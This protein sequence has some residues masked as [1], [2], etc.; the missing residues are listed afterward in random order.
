[1]NKSLCNHVQELKSALLNMKSTGET[2]FEGLISVTLREISG[3]PFRLARSG[4]QYGVDGKPAYPGDA[5]CFECKRYRKGIRRNEVISKIGELLISDAEV[6]IWVL[7]A[8][9]QIGTT[10]A[11]DIRDL[12]NKIGIFIL[13][14]DWSEIDLP[15]FAVALAMGKTRVRKFLKDNIGDVKTLRKAFA[16]LKAI[17]NSHDFTTHAD[18]IQKQCNDPAL[19]ITLAQRANSELLSEIFTSR[20]LAKTKFGQ[21]LSP[22]DT[23]LPNVRERKVL[24]D[25][26]QPYFSSPPDNTVNFVVGGEGYGK[27]WIVAQTWMA[28]ENKPLMVLMTP[29]DFTKP[30]GQLNVEDLI[31]TKISDQTEKETTVVTKKQ[32]YR[33]FEKWRN[34]PLVDI[35]RVIVVIDGINQRPTY[36]WARYIDS[37]SSELFKLGGRLIVTSRTSYFAN[38]VK[39]RLDVGFTETTVPEWTI[40]EL[41]EILFEHNIKASDLQPDVTRSLRNPRL[42]GIALEILNRDDITNFKELS[43]SRLLFE[44][45]RMSEKDALV[46]QSAR[47]FA[48]RLQTHAKKILRR[49]HSKQ[50]DDLNIFDDQMRF[51]ADGRFFNAV[52]DDPT[53][54]FINDDGL[55]LALGFAVINLLRTAQRNNRNLDAELDMILDPISALDDTSNAIL[56]ALT[57]TTI[58]KS[59]SRDITVS[60]IQGFA[61]LQN[62]DQTKFFAFASLARS[63]PQDFMDAAR[64]LCL[65]AEYQPNFDWIQTALINAGQNSH[66]WHV[67]ASNIHSWLAVYSLSPKR[68][69]FLVS[70]RSSQE[71]IKEEYEKNRNKIEAKINLFSKNERSILRNLNKENGDLSSLSRLAFILLAGKPLALFSLSFLNWSFSKALNPDH[72]EP[73]KEFIDLVTLNKVDWLDTR[74]ALLEVSEKLGDIDVSETGKWAL[75]TILRATGHSD[76]GKE[77]KSILKDLTKDWPHRESWSLI[78]DYCSTDPCNPAST[79]PKNITKTAEKYAALD[80][81]KLRNYS[82]QTSEDLF[83]SMA[84]PGIA[85]FKPKIAIAKHLEFAADVLNR[86]GSPLRQG[87]FELCLNN[88]LLT[89]NIAREFIKK[90]DV[91]KTTDNTDDLLEQDVSQYIL[92]LA[93]PFLTAREQVDI[94]LSN[95]ADDYIPINLKELAKPLGEAEFEKLLETVCVGHNE[96]N[97]YLLLDLATSTSIRLSTNARAHIT[98][99][100]QS[101]SE[102]VRVQALVIIAQSGDNEMLTQVVKSKW[103][104]AAIKKENDTEIRY[105]S[106]ALLKAAERGLL[107]HNEALDRIS[108]RLYGR[109]AT[110]LG[111]DAIK[112]VVHR[113]DTLIKNVASLDC[114]LSAPKIEIQESGMILVDELSSEDKNYN[115]FHEFMANLT[116]SN[117]RIL[118]D[119]ITLK[120]FAALISSAEEY[121]DSWYRLF[122]SISVD[123]L[124]TVHNFVILLTHTLALKDPRK[125][126]ELFR[127][128]N[129]ID[130]LV[131]FTFGRAGDSFNANTMWGGVRSPV[132]DDIR[133]ARLDQMK[134]DHDLSNEVLTALLN[135]QQELLSVYIEAKLNK[136]EPA[137]ISRGLMVAGYS[138]QSEFN[139]DII[140]RY[141]STAGLIGSSQKAAKYAYERNL[142]ARHWFSK[143]CQTGKNTDFW[144][145][146][147]LFLKIVDGRFY[148][149]Y[150]N[151]KQNGDPIRSFGAT[152]NLGIKTRITK[153]EN[154]RKKKLFGSNAPNPIFI[155]S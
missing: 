58:D 5:I 110:I 117:A 15:P 64:V 28:L 133:F 72:T 10:L 102:R 137:E 129:D 24:I 112:K 84:R 65:A 27:S 8:T 7:G 116:K 144:R 39:N 29:K 98:A 47:E 131:L 154:H 40:P 11:D 16:A 23:N 73:N 1:M 134:T 145:Y 81:S 32:W 111:L 97:Q 34:H 12:G 56:A 155:D 108:P 78:E 106:L 91:A 63:S 21:P 149:W 17:R 48:G 130:P 61:A 139:D 45:M 70:A 85:R 60:L 115:T 76:D 128:V 49:V 26:L 101:E 124:A 93:F 80:T 103:N 118:L 46:P 146:Q 50:T 126:K 54:Y 100:L 59:Y 141:E 9:S 71:K 52:K 105:G 41:D 69:T 92:Q 95:E 35:P 2:G 51:V 94:L 42:L 104:A 4:L 123:K 3:V 43:V 127:R 74:I 19:G 44:H 62:P 77:V 22:G 119:K 6:D 136:E 96:Q 31:I 30:I 67:M 82:V 132:L 142:W 13:I 83:F 135:D 25:K 120:E 20:K 57:V 33:R 14:L 125:A 66:A 113:L 89:I 38:H 53:L 140:R 18:K 86:T 109:A 122:M 138:D 151:H 143:M 99:L 75:V 147:I 68:G 107:A 37:V 121:V 88:A 152:L 79:Q 153:W 150:R 114:D 148:V 55:T 90:R 36:D 87:L